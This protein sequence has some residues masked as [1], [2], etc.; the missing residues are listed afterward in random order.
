MKFIAQ[1]TILSKV[2][3]HNERQVHAQRLN[4]PVEEIPLTF[5]SLRMGVNLIA[6]YEND[7]RV[8]YNVDRRSTDKDI[9]EQRLILEI[10]FKYDRDGNVIEA[11]EVV[12]E[13]VKGQQFELTMDS[14]FIT[15][16]HYL[17]FVSGGKGRTI[18]SYFIKSW[19]DK[20]NF[21]STPELQ[22]G[23]QLITPKQVVQRVSLDKELIIA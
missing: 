23:T 4:K 8:V 10:S 16:N 12:N 11:H 13:L 2:A 5:G 20:I 19:A 6:F 1:G 7:Q 15:K 9:K 17:K 22:M 14:A 3:C 18:K 21:L